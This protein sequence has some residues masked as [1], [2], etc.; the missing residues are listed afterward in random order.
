MLELE[1]YER[2]PDM[3][4]SSPKCPSCWA[5]GQP[6][7]DESEDGGGTRNKHAVASMCNGAFVQPRWSTSLFNRI[8]T[9]STCSPRPRT[10]YKASSSMHASSPFANR[11]FM[12]SSL[13]LVLALCSLNNQLNLVNCITVRDPGSSDISRTPPAPV[14]GKS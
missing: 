11:A 10:K 4:P 9:L 5:S 6:N 8:K 12:A 3:H 13:F 1:D 7:A 14:K 2:V